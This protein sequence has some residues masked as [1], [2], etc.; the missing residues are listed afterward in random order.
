[1][2]GILRMQNTEYAWRKRSFRN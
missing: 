1:M 2:L